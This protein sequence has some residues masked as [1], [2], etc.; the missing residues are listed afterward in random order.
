MSSNITNHCHTQ[1]NSFFA[2]SLFVCKQ[3]SAKEKVDIYPIQKYHL[4]KRP[5]IPKICK[6]Y[7]KVVP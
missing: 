7:E 1:S 5:P 2:H 3:S 4:V 6:M